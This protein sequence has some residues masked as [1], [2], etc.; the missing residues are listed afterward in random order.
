MIGAAG[1]IKRERAAI[2]SNGK[3]A[4]SEVCRNEYDKAFGIPGTHTPPMLTVTL[5]S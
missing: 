5:A 2:E 1:D 3:M 4:Q